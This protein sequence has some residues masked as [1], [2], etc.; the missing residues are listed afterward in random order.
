[1]VAI[2]VGPGSSWSV[3]SADD[4]PLIF[5]A[6]KMILPAKPTYQLDGDGL[7]SY[8]N[9]V[10]TRREETFRDLEQLNIPERV[11]LPNFP[12]INKNG[13]NVMMFCF[14][15]DDT[16]DDD[17]EHNNNK[18]ANEDQNTKSREEK[19]EEDELIAILA[20]VQSLGGLQAEDFEYAPPVKG[21]ALAAKGGAGGA[22]TAS[23]GEKACVGPTAEAPADKAEVAHAASVGEQDGIGGA[24]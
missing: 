2:K 4:P 10:E 8:F 20:E 19:A 17:Q 24:V 16:D 21:A 1:M 7:K 13:A 18:N 15:E 22:A 14:P 6:K 12:V 9:D 23:A 11:L 3:G 5:K